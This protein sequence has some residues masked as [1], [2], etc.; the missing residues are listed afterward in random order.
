[1]C[2]RARFIVPA[3]SVGVFL[4]RPRVQISSR[5]LLLLQIWDSNP[6][7]QVFGP[8]GSLSVLLTDQGFEPCV[9]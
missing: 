2:D 8:Q 9:T 1:M 7:Y 4:R 3:L 6:E 5:P